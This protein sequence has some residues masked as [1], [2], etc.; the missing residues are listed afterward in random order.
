MFESLALIRIKNC[1]PSP[2]ILDG[3]LIK[4][5]KGIKTTLE[6]K[7]RALFTEAWSLHVILSLT[8]WL[9]FHLE[10]GG[11][12]SLLILP[13]FLRSDQGGLSVSLLLRENWRTPVAYVGDTNSLSWNFISFPRKQSYSASFLHWIVSL[14]S[15]YLITISLIL[16][17]P[18]RQSRLPFETPDSNGAWP[19]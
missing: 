16:P 10:R 18:D 1:W 8:F 11:L 15:P 17:Y 19:R 3:Q 5:I 6:N 4:G 14:S 13:G 12:S 2:I 7:V 9:N